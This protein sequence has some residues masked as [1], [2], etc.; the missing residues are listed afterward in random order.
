MTDARVDQ[1]VAMRVTGHLTA[2]VFQRYRITTDD[3]VRAALERTEAANAQATTART[4]VPL[5]AVQGGASRS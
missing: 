5:R 3:D 4:V 1:R 2:S